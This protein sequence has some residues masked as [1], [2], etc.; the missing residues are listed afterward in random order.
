MEIRSTSWHETCIIRAQR[1]FL[2]CCWARGWGL[3]G[4]P[5]G[6]PIVIREVIHMISTLL[7]AAALLVAVV[8]LI[9][10]YQARSY[11]HNCTEF[12]AKVSRSAPQFDELA[13]LGVELTTQR[14]ALAQISKGL[15]TIRNRMNVRETN[16]RR[17]VEAETEDDAEWLRKT[18]AQLQVGAQ[19]RKEQ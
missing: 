19:P 4:A 16:A 7:A 3:E 18:T 1:E 13:T 12:V 5:P 6:A 8:A 15:R 10:A 14:D 9:I 11:A 17:K 2:P